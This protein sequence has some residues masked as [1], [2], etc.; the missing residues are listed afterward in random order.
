MSA[1]A[2]PVFAL[3]DTS[4]RTVA[5]VHGHAGLDAW[6]AQRE[7]VAAAGLQRLRSGGTLAFGVDAV[8]VVQVD[9]GDE[10]VLGE[11]TPPSGLVADGIRRG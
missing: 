11:W 1:G 7:A 9:G 3:R 4:G 10:R 6:K 5:T 2:V 8:S